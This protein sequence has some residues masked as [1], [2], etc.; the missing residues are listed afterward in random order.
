[1]AGGGELVS[2]GGTVDGLSV[3]VATAVGEA[4]VVA[5]GWATVGFDA[6]TVGDPADRVTVAAMGCGVGAAFDALGS[7]MRQAPAQQAKS[8]KPPQPNPIRPRG[9]PSLRRQPNEKPPGKRW[10]QPMYQLLMRPPM[11]L[12]RRDYGPKLNTARSDP[13]SI[14]T[15]SSSPTFAFLVVHDV[16]SC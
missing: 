4:A 5:L 14:N 2:V 6:R 7:A 13:V 1:M 15:S 11:R 10:R 8:T 16:V 3:A 9:V 12:R